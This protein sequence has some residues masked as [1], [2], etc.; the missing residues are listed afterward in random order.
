[1]HEVCVSRD[2]ADH[3][4]FGDRYAQIVHGILVELIG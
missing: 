4:R 2:L 3:K 1:M